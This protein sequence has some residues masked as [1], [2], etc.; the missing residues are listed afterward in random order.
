[1]FSGLQHAFRLVFTWI[2]E[3][4]RP[5]QLHSVLSLRTALTVYISLQLSAYCYPES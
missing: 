4:G 5:S 1:M 2:L 3:D